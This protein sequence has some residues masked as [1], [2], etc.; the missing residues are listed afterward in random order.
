MIVVME[1][2]R[3]REIHNISNC[4]FGTI[5]RI[6]HTDLTIDARIP[7]RF[8]KSLRASQQRHEC[9][10]HDVVMTLGRFYCRYL[11]NARDLMPNFHPILF[12][13]CAF[14]NYMLVYNM[15]ITNLAAIFLE[16]FEPPSFIWS[17]TVDDWICIQSSPVEKMHNPMGRGSLRSAVCSTWC[18]LVIAAFILNRKRNATIG[19]RRFS[20]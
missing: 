9:V 4:S 17:T 16:P 11:R 13:F 12:K 6:I 10:K 7:C 20:S 5:H 1:K 8:K 3:T 19:H 14:L 15:T 2:S 18:S